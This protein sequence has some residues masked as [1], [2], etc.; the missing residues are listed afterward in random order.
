MLA[1]HSPQALT[2]ACLWPSPAGL[3]CLGWGEPPVPLALALRPVQLPPVLSLCWHCGQ[4]GTGPEPSGWECCRRILVSSRKLGLKFIEYSNY[5][6]HIQPWWL[7]VRAVVWYQ[8]SLYLGG[9]IPAWG[10]YD[11]MVPLDPLCYVRPGCVLYVC[12][13]CNLYHVFSTLRVLSQK[14]YKNVHSNIT[15]LNCSCILKGE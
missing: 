3:C 7:G 5:S 15:N 2:L 9:S 8:N 13:T 14:N 11:Y 1:M 4:P 12:V 6:I 10:I